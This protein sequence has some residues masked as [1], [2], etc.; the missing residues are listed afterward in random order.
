M[1]KE[2]F[3]AISEWQKET[4][5]QATALS[6]IAHL[7]QEINEL[8]CELNQFNNPT[9]TL[10]EFADC[11]ILLFGSAASYGMNY[12]DICEAVNAK[13]NINIKRS[14][15]EPDLNGVVNHIK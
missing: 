4:F 3:E 13:M 8:E 10:M 9:G 5:G 2:Q 12:E 1:T 14:W 11:F 7:K 15:G 6:K